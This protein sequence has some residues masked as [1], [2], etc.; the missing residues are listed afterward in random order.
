MIRWLATDAANWRFPWGW[1]YRNVLGNIVASI[2]WAGPP[3]V[4][5]AWWGNRRAHKSDE[6]REWT[7]RALAQLHDATTPE[8]VQLA[9]HPHHGQLSESAS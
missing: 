1:L 9:P 2:M 5:G 7:A 6:H 3:F 8:S 4:L